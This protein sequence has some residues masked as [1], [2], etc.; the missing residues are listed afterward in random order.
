MQ[1]RKRL[2]A[3]LLSAAL[4]I[5]AV[6]AAQAAGPDPDVTGSI[7]GTV[8]I[9]SPQSL[10]ALKDRDLR[11]ELS[12][13]GDALGWFPLTWDGESFSLGVYDASVS[14]RNQ[15]GGPL[16]GGR[17]PGYLDFTVSGLPQGDY[18]LSFT[19]EGYV[20][21]D[22][23]V[24][25]DRYAQH[26][27]LGTADGTFT[28]GDVNGDGRVNER[29]RDLLADALG[30]T[31]ARDLSHYDLT[32]DGEIDIYDLACVTRGMGAS[33]GA[34]I[35]DTACLAPPVDFDAMEA[36]LDASGVTFTGD[37]ADLFRDNGEIVL[38]SAGGDGDTTLEIPLTEAVEVQELKIL[39]PEGPG[40]MLAGT[41]RLTYSDD[42]YEEAPF[43][44][45]APAGVHTISAVPGSGVITIALGRRVAVKKITITVTR[46]ADGDYAAVESIQFLRDIVPENPV[47][48]NSQ[49][50]N[51][52]A[53]PGDGKVDLRWSTL[54]NV[55]GYRVD[56]WA[57][58]GS[59]Q[60]KSL[61]VS[62]PSASVTGLENLKVY[63]FTVTPVNGAWQGLAS[64]A[65]TAEPQPSKAP[66]AP[67]MIN[68]QS[69]DSALQ[70][71]WKASKGATYYQL[72]YKAE[73]DADYRLWGDRIA[74]TSAALTG[75]TNDVTYSLY[76]TAG[77][78]VGVSGRSRIAQGVPKGV[79]YSRPEGIPTEGVIEGA[80]IERVWLAD[81]GN[82]S[83]SSYPAGAPFQTAYMNDGD[84]RT[85]WTSQSYYDGNWSRSKTVYASFARPVDLSAVIWVPR[86]DGGYP[87]N[88]R[89]Y[90]VT[91]WQEGD[92][93]SGPGTLIAPLPN[94]GSGSDVKTWLPV[95]NNPAVTRFALLPFNPAMKVVKIA[96]TI[97][98]VDYTAVSLSE[99]MFLE[100]D[101]AHC[102]PE[103]IAALF[104][105][106]T[107]LSL[108]TGADQAQIDALRTRLT[109]DERKYCI[110]P[111][112]L[113][114]E[115]DLAEELLNGV[116][117]SGVVIEGV[118]ARSAG[119]DS[120]KY[121]QSGSDLQ[122][123][124]AAAAA[125]S[126]IT[127]YASG[128]P[129]GETV[130]IFATQFNAE[131]STWR[132]QAGTLENGR[133]I[134]R[135]PQIGS[136]NTPRGGSLYFTYSGSNPDGIT[137]HVRRATD[138]PALDLSD[139][140]TMS[141]TA[142]QDAIGLY[143]DELDAYVTAQGINDTNKLTNC[144]N[145][146]EIATP[147]V[148]LSLPAA[149]VLG[150]A[151]RDRAERINTLY[152]SVLAW[153]DI[154][155]ICNTTQGIDST[156]DKND[157]QSRQNI[158]CMQMFSGAFMYAAGNHVGI[159]YGSCG[160]MVCGK[161]IEALNGASANGLFGWGIAHEI[162]HNMDKLGKAEITN[163]IYSLMVQTCDGGQ[164]VL[165]SR[166]ENSNKYSAIF[167]KV[168]E[169]YPGDSNNVFVQLGL[170]WQLHLAYD[171][172]TNP[173]DFYNRFFKAWKAGTHFNGASDY[174]DRLA[175][176]ASA[177]ANKNLT[178]FFTRWGVSLS[179]NTRNTLAGYPEEPRAVWYLSDQSRRARLNGEQPASGSLTASAALTGEKKNEVT[180]TITPN[181]TGDLQGY[182]IRRSSDGGQTFQS[183][184]FTKDTSYTDVIGSANHRT[185]T[186]QVVAYDILGNAVNNPA[187]SKSNEI[188]IAYDQ[189]VPSGDYTMTRDGDG[190]VTFDLTNE[191]AVSGLIL[192]GANIPASGD[193]TITVTD[194]DGKTT[195]AR[196]GSFSANNQATDNTN[197]YLTYFQ[198][199]G[200]P[201]TDTR[202]WTYDAKTVTVTGI[203]ADVAEGDI[204]LIS[205]AGDDVALWEGGFAGLLAAPYDCGSETLPAGTLVIAGTYRG[206][207][208]YQIVKI[209]GLFTKTV[210]ADGENSAGTVTQTTET[211][212]LDGEAYLFAEVP[213]DG[214]VSDI[215][216]GIFL[217]VPNVQREAELQ[218]ETHDCA[219]TNLLPTQ[220]RAVLSRSDIPNDAAD[221]RITAETLWVNA[222]GGED[223]PTIV[224][225]QEAAQ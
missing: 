84:F 130:R 30:S 137:L 156:R 126:E 22:Q 45:S 159:G 4:L 23:D 19:G 123:L 57:K 9:D 195:T 61:T 121:H 168:A 89:V 81:A 188:R 180:I 66:D 7:S 40:E 224:I 80:A 106:E 214:E 192:T 202:I 190:T 189:T 68:V 157:M 113:D 59:G 147:V 65:V 17:W 5:P 21:C 219:P 114:D 26:I 215:S 110:N 63:C 212:F 36:A 33:G 87:S 44:N 116:A 74:G 136:Q 49:V 208:G 115:L 25:L 181:I 120:N 62:V 103:D 34:Q 134:L 150:G 222:P 179:E 142:R 2:T 187:D 76:L 99:L 200:A 204:N 24:T 56:W 196:T 158:R 199:P 221:Q 83:P 148:L 41:V 171:G 31:N 98:Q 10:D 141:E 8:R 11:V 51:L 118:D 50:R 39:T 3:L 172:G 154:M 153:E 176:T 217:F 105:D 32:G 152:Q 163:N 146:T 209:E 38:F 124:G 86:L 92:D 101:P 35:L 135:I 129:A 225:T 127:I 107:R 95:Q 70:V 96:I 143:M 211:R 78:A 60:R 184:A 46:T 15:D 205:Y 88:L 220:I 162:G 20:P 58:D 139:W 102:L 140:Y 155:H 119:A 216:D 93:L 201:K 47:A 185:Y 42:T 112:A 111:T 193:F 122:P 131:A 54:P 53:E 218:G 13:D 94:C 85:H 29:D 197:S 160:G 178:E 71:S 16:G 67:D 173:F 100:Y 182:E 186:Y 128:I 69:Q 12:Q 223:L 138:I 210:L 161:P 174:G 72:Y 175:L 207:P 73:S 166:L 37:L 177:I 55:T 194:K 79:D 117:S 14:L 109:G 90:T 18:T 164:N 206:N 151:G 48:P 75:L 191:T 27:I 28:L 132:A 167:T 104:A 1:I 203:P 43:D 169:G 165:R 149:A 64:E 133:N 108:R 77:N 125:N 97:E 91:V 145:V 82:V 183:I 213:D 144:L 52:S 6:P 198:K 170:Y